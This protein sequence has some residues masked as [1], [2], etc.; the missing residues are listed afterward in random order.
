VNQQNTT[1]LQNQQ[2]VQLDGL[3]GHL[4]S[5]SG[6][7]SKET[8]LSLYS[9][10]IRM[11]RDHRMCG[12]VMTRTLGDES[13]DSMA[14]ALDG[15][16]DLSCYRLDEP[17]I[18]PVESGIS[19][20]TGFL[21]V[22]TDRLCVALYW[23][24]QTQ[25]TF[26]MY[27][28]GWTF[29]PG[30]VRTIVGHMINHLEHPQ[31]KNIL[32]VSLEETPIDRRYDEKLNILLTSLVNGLEN[33]N[34]EL[35]LALE[36]V[37]E[38][39]RKMVE[40]ERLAAVGQLCSVIAHEIRNPLGLIDLYAK[41]VEEQ[42]KQL[43]VSPITPEA[44]QNTEAPAPVAIELPG[45]RQGLLMKNLSFIRQSASNLETILTELTSY[46]RPLQ[47]QLEQTDIVAMVK[48]TCDFY[49]ASYQEKS[50]QLQFQIAIHEGEPQPILINL[51]CG[52]IR[53]AV[54]NL[55]KNALEVSPAESKV[56]VT[57]ACRKSDKNI[58]IKVKD[59]GP[60]VDSVVA[61]KLFTPYFSTKGNGTGLGLAH[62]RK[63][64]Q[65]HGGSVE[66]L[67]G[68]RSKDGLSDS[69]DGATFAIILPR[70]IE[71]KTN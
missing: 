66:L 54:I 40:Q 62:S 12:F 20:T 26:R 38:L 64:L 55:L 34:R 35:T 37:N 42:L 71:A 31:Y 67:S 56:Q 43:G 48:D 53:Q 5:C 11:I 45:E 51:D 8:F 30:D 1:P 14:Y 46:S 68:V 39:S 27:E 49:S 4:S 60:G 10:I 36:K 3:L 28:G 9:C 22:L 13:F 59:Q 58:Y 25:E 6:L 2:L 57:V 33:R 21:L 18:L 52:K 70:Q 23:S 16:P 41:L 47:L 17:S 24:S 50:V 7:Y 15:L 32:K 19:E 63:I 29:H 65:A 69:P 44:E 61:Q